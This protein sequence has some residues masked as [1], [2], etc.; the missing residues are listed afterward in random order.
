MIV[1]Y[2]VMPC[3]TECY[4]DAR[5]ISS[6]LSDLSLLLSTY[7]TRDDSGC[8]T[9]SSEAYL[10]EVARR[11]R[12]FH[13]LYWSTVVKRFA[14]VHSDA[15]LHALEA[16]GYLLPNER[17]VLTSNGALP[18]SQ[19]VHTVL[20]WIGTSVHSGN[21]M[22]ALSSGSSKT[23]IEDEWLVRLNALRSAYG[24][25]GK[26]LARRMPL[27]YVHLVQTLVDTTLLMAP[28]ALYGRLGAVSI[29]LCGVL[30]FFYRGLLDVSKS[31]LDPFGNDGT[32]AEIEVPVIVRD[33]NQASVRFIDGAEELP[34]M[35]LP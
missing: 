5:S 22:G 29:I 3:R 28:F 34:S 21:A 10:R 33:A 17:A 20:T 27:V 13:V 30:T 26:A 11:M 14:T 25:I 7:A 2:S 1:P 12:L 31:F 4:I 15:G 23:A 6:R 24:K 35:A 19:R 9:A 18:P 8:L 32:A 16:S